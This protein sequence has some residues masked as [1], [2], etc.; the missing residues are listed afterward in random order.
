[1]ITAVAP[2]TVVASI[3]VSASEREVSM[4]T[5][6]HR[7]SNVASPDADRE[8]EMASGCLLG[9]CEGNPAY[10]DGWATSGQPSLSEPDIADKVISDRSP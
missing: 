10:N 6:Y 8:V 2:S 5:S 1:M 7:V 9:C 4:G 3:V